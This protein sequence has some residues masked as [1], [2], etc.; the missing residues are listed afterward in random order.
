MA[1]IKSANSEDQL[2]IDPISKAARITGYKPDG[3]LA[4]GFAIRNHYRAATTAVFAAAAGTSPFFAIQGS[5]TKTIRIIS[6]K[7]TGP[8]L[9]AAAYLNV[10]CQRRSTVTTGG[11]AT[12]L[13]L[14][15]NDSIHP[16]GTL[17]L[18]NIYTA[19]PTAGTLI[20]TVGSIRFLAADTTP[21]TLVAGLDEFLFYKDHEDGMVLRGINEGVTL[22]FSSAPGSVVTMNLEVVWTE[23]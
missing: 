4:T 9:T 18:C 8:T 22:S 23:E 11:T 13:I 5:S 3:S 1:I 16:S 17:S 6:I 19:A 7:I 20:G 2:I 21:V 14:V 12:A 15:P 10:I